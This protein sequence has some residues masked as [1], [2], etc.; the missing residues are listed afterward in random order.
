LMQIIK[1]KAKVDAEGEVTIKMPQDLANQELEIAIVY[2][3]V[4]SENS[5]ELH[6]AIDSFYGCL[7][8]DP[9]VVEEQNQQEMR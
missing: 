3:K 7:A 2:Q 8:D 6:E 9:I 1:L 4:E 5:K